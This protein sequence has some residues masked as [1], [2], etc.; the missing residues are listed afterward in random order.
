[1]VCFRGYLGW[2]LKSLEILAFFSPHQKE[3]WGSSPAL[4]QWCCGCGWSQFR[5]RHC[6]GVSFRCCSPDILGLCLIDFLSIWD[7]SFYMMHEYPYVSTSKNFT[8]TSSGNWHTRTSSWSNSFAFAPEL[9]PTRFL[10]G[11]PYDCAYQQLGAA[12]GLAKL[13]QWGCWKPA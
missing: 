11:R 13:S 7:Q 6:G 4:S 8:L 12:I 10:A 3:T 9:A 5:D 2:L 1:M